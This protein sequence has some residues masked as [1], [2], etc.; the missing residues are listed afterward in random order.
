MYSKLDE[1][2]VFTL[3]DLGGVSGSTGL[4]R[5]STLGVMAQNGP[6]DVTDLAFRRG[7]E[8]WDKWK[9][10]EDEGSAT[11]ASCKEPIDISVGSC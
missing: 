8:V 3:L 10:I 2:P 7:I 4:R 5:N 6:I 9:T 11:C 1:I